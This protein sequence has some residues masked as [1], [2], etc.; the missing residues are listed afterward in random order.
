MYETDL[1]KFL[2]VNLRNKTVMILETNGLT[3]LSNGVLPLRSHALIQSLSNMD[4]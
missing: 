2:I 1:S 4:L 3:A